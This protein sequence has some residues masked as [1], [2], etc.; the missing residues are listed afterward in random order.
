MS[1]IAQIVASCSVY[2]NVFYELGCFP[3]VAR[4]TADSSKTNSKFPEGTLN[5]VLADKR[6]RP[7]DVPG[8]KCSSITGVGV[9]RVWQA[10]TCR[11]HARRFPGGSFT[12][13]PLYQQ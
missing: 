3:G 8:V 11:A 9:E 2:F 5:E 10:A 1:I 4:T 6:N 12:T 7:L 13:L